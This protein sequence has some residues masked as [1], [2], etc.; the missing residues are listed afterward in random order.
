[1]G[2]VAKNKQ[3]GENVITVEAWLETINNPDYV[4]A[5]NARSAGPTPI[6]DEMWYAYLDAVNAELVEETVPEGDNV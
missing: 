1:M 6:F 3:T 5:W 4:E 2:L